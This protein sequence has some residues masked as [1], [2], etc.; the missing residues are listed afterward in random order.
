LWA[1]TGLNTFSS[2]L[3]WLPATPMAASLPMTCTH[4]IVMASACVGFTLPGMIELPGSFAGM[5][6]SP[7]P[8]R[9]PEASQRT[10]LAIFMQAPPAA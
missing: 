1:I 9:G 7:M 10:S 8:Q 5:R 3:P 4:T 2:K 6:S